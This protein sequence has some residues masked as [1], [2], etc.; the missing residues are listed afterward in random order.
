MY[1]DFDLGLNKKD[2]MTRMG[3]GH[4]INGT[5]NGGG[6]DLQLKTISSDIYIRKQK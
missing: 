2:G 1:T 4:S 3:G 5:T 6:V